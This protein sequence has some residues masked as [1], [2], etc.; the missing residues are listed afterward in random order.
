[1][2]EHVPQLAPVTMLENPKKNM[3]EFSFGNQDE[4][5]YPKKYTKP[6]KSPKKIKKETSK[7]KRVTSKSP[8]KKKGIFL[9]NTVSPTKLEFGF[10]LRP[11]EGACAGA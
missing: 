11:G 2:K 5:M 1:M 3:N 7:S 10:F 4:I 6:S 8:K 9:S